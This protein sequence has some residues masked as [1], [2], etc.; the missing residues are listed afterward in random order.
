MKNVLQLLFRVSHLGTGM[1]NWSQRR[2]VSLN[3][4][5]I[6]VWSL[7]TL[8]IPMPD[9]TVSNYGRLL[10]GTTCAPVDALYFAMVSRPELVYAVYREDISESGVPSSHWT[11]G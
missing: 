11:G 5:C 9:H 8:G 6:V 4:N 3:D 1:F 10:G 2:Y 7:E